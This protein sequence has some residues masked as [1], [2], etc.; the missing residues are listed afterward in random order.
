[1]RSSGSLRWSL[2]R[3]A[4]VSRSSETIKSDEMKLARRAWRDRGVV[5]LRVEELEH[6]WLRHAIEALATELYGPRRMGPLREG[7]KTAKE[8]E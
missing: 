4:A 6:E 5:L 3:S 7:P 1:M 8:V 2:P